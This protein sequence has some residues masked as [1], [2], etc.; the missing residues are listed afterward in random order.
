MTVSSL[1]SVL[2]ALLQGASDIHGIGGWWAL[3]V[4]WWQREENLGLSRNWTAAIQ[5]IGTHY[6]DSALQAHIVLYNDKK[7]YVHTNITPILK[8]NYEILE[9]LHILHES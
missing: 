7:R 4:V 8:R 5:L 6:S 3:E 1:L 2:D 9:L